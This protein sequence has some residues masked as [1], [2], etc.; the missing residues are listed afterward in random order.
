M[1]RPTTLVSSKPLDL[2]LG[3][4]VL[5]ASET[6]QVTGSF[7]FRAAF[8]LA[9]HVSQRL[10]IGASSGNFGLGLA[11]ACRLLDKQCIVVMPD[12]SSRAKID[13]IRACGGRIEFIQTQVVSRQARVRQLLEE[14]PEAYEASAYDDPLVIAG[15]ATL[16]VELAALPDPIDC[17]LAPIGGGGLAA[18]LITGL[19]QAGRQIPVF[20]VEPLLANDAARSLRAGRIVVQE[21]EPQT[22]ADGVRTLSLGRNTWEILHKG[23]AGIIEVPEDAIAQALGLL[24][25]V[26][27][28]K[29]EPTGALS[30][31]ALLVQPD[32]FRGQNVCCVISGGNVD[33]GLFC[34]LLQNYSVRGTNTTP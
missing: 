32:R 21:T 17:I 12:N 27:N 25:N 22:I 8:H 20:G 1:M 2:C 13:A 24:F 30:M 15:N 34:Q 26:A 19:R 3:S 6:F 5:L 31:A 33:A 4:R 10:M 18:G 16:G 23:L 9:S 14:H 28:L 29:A 7:K 11:Q